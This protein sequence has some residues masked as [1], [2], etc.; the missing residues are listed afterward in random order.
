MVSGKK[1]KKL[2]ACRKQSR[3][4][5]LIRL[6]KYLADSGVAS[7]RASEKL[8]TAGRVTVDGLVVT[9]LGVKIES[10]RQV[11]RFDGEIV[12]PSSVFFY[13][14]MHKPRGFV[15]TAFDEKGR[16][17]VYDLLPSCAARL[18]YVGRLD[19][20]SEGLL[21][22]T[23]HGELLYRLTHPR[24][25]IAKK[26]HAYCDRALT[27]A[28]EAALLRGVHDAGDILCALACRRLDVSG[29]HGYEVVLG[30]GKNRHIRRMF[31]CLGVSVQRLIRVEMGTMQ[32]DGLRS[33]EVRP[34]NEAE[35][36]RLLQAT[37]I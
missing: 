21:L 30:E 5:N 3:L 37:G 15:C 8:I 27:A 4:T 25:H 18:N 36:H 32:L 19:C 35:I 14:L 23:N 34:L 7:R 6:Q 33:G 9:E 20:D 28:D 29:Q 17:T 12:R 31:A 2:L 10:G 13:Y 11:V 24:Y 22:F 1:A 16:K 26:Y